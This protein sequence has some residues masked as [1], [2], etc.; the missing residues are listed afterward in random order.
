MISC[1]KL[2]RVIFEQDKP[3]FGVSIESL[4]R[5]ILNEEQEDVPLLT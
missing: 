5:T 3:L 2:A 1:F 4:L